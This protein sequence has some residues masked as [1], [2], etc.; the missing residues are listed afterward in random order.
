MVSK[1]DSKKVIRVS[2]GEKNCQKWVEKG[3]KMGFRDG[4]SEKIGSGPS[5]VGGMAS[6]VD[7]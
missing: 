3:F 6:F 4:K 2:K 5:W 1:T 7:G